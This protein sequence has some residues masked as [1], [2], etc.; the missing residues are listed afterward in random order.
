MQRFPQ[1]SAENLYLVEH[2]NVLRQSLQHY[3]HRD[4]VESSLSE[5]EAAKAIYFA[6]FIVVSHGTEADPI[7]NYGNRAALEL[8]EI[9]WEELT[10]LPSRQSAEPPNQEE[11]SQL[12]A[13]VSTRGV[14]ENYAGI[15]ISQ[16]GR[17]FL[18]QQ[19][20]IWNLI[21]SARVFQ[22]QAA[23]YSDWKYL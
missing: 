13:A 7:F 8:F 23:V 14:V 17:R 10:A 1:P 6:P 2:I 18:I 20:T 16:T 5:V 9:T 12:L 19:V 22:G 4:L 21:D 15:R 11:R 3:A